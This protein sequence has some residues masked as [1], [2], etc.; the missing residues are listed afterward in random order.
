[1]T[2]ELCP[3]TAAVLVASFYKFVTLPTPRSV[4]ALLGARAREFGLLGTLL[5]AEEGL[6]ASIAM[7][8]VLAALVIPLLPTFT[9]PLA[10]R[11]PSRR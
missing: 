6:N 11:E 2:T 1:M 10:S 9:Q 7:T 3:S 8:L 4:G 5:L